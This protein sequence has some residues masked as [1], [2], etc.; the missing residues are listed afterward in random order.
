LAFKEA[1]NVAEL[2][3]IGEPERRFYRE[4]RLAGFAVA[5]YDE[6]SG[7]EQVFDVGQLRLRFSVTKQG[8]PAINVRFDPW[9]ARFSGQGVHFT[10]SELM[11]RPEVCLNRLF[12]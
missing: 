12:S 3:L 6:S 2:S 1:S 8:R 9:T 10:W 11:F 7:G 4:C 5:V